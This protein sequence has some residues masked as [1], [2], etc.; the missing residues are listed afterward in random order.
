MEE[1]AYDYDRERAIEKFG[2]IS[3][4][5]PFIKEK[6]F[7]HPNDFFFSQKTIMN[8]GWKAMCQPP[9]PATSMVV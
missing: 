9:R 4:N 1:P 3:K 2:L 6:G 8:K 7:H 5:R